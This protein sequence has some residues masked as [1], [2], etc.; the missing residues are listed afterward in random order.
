MRLF[1]F[2][3]LFCVLAFTFL[4]GE[5]G[6]RFVTLVYHFEEPALGFVDFFPL[7]FNLYFIYL[8]TLGFVLLFG[9]LLGD[10]LGCLLEIFLVF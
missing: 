8:L 4:L 2:R 5:P 7:F 1:S 6:Q 10:R 9:I 3:F